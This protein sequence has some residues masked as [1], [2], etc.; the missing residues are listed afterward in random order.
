MGNA[1]LSRLQV[2]LGCVALLA[3]SHA[4]LG[5][6]TEKKVSAAPERVRVAGIVLKWKMGD[7]ETNYGNAERLIREA[8]RR[9]A[10]IVCTPESFLDGY[11]VRDDS[12]SVARFRD[13][14]ES[15]PGGE[16]CSRLR[17][18][19]DELNI[20]LIAAISELD[21]ENVYNSALLIG[22]DGELLGRYRKR[23][24][25]ADEKSKYTAGETFTVFA[26]PHGKIGMMICSDRRQAAAIEELV[27]NG[28]ELVFCPA[29]GG[30]GPDNDMIVAQRSKEGAVPIVFV[31]PI[32]F[33]VTGRDGEVLTSE[34]FG[35]SLDLEDASAV[36]GVMRYYDLTL[37]STAPH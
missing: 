4:Y 11:S 2:Y 21:G 17:R 9:G 28:A 23:Y 36:P 33:L 5:C 6:A 25:W 10:D 32:E 1:G 15:A 31:H 24:L 27:A 37:H 34:L 35:D 16:Y 19:T 22:P 18:L 3:C 14:A 8:A 7:R 26:T 29:G 20:H 13:L 30:Y 12:L